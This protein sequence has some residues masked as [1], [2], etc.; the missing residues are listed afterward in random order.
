ME[1]C[2]STASEFFIRETFQIC[3]AAKV[4]NVGTNKIRTVVKMRQRQRK[5]TEVDPG[6]IGHG[7]A[8]IIHNPIVLLYQ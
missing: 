1:L 8:I 2:E 4:L 5:A 6:H 7:S 3:E